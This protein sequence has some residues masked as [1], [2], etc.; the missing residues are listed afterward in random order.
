[1]LLFKE[2]LL[3]QYRYVLQKK[4]FGRGPAGHLLGQKS[5]E[6]FDPLLNKVVIVHFSHPE[7]VLKGSFYSK[8][9]FQTST[10][11]QD[12]L[13]NQLFLIKFIK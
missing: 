3:N 6:I 11:M 8:K 10:N 9:S 12:P 7:H 1:M 2:K 5:L 13:L 4:K